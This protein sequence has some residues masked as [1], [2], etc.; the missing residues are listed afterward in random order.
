M[1]RR[2]WVSTRTPIQTLTVVAK[3][4]SRSRDFDATCR[5]GCRATYAIANRRLPQPYRL[6]DPVDQARRLHAQRTP[7]EICDE[8]YEALH[9]SPFIDASGIAITVEDSRVMLEGTVNSLMAISLAK[10]LTN[11]VRGV[12]RVQVRLRVEPVTQVHET[13]VTP[14][15]KVAD[16]G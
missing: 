10:A 14:L 8:V 13:A 9:A 3:K 11:G 1:G 7:R 5:S 16:I 15:Y 12:G 4:P 2:Q 6:P